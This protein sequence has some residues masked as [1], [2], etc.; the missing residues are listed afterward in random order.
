[1]GFCAR[2]AGERRAHS[3]WLRLKE[4]WLKVGVNLSQD[5]WKRPRDIKTQE[6]IWIA[7]VRQKIGKCNRV[8]F[9]RSFYYKGNFT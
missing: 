7:M 5:L 6:Y 9:R 1:M 4:G 2:R 8:L 3:N